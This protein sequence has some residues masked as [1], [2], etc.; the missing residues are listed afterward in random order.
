MPAP[1]NVLFICTGNCCRSQMSEAILRHYGGDR[2]NA[3]SAGAEPAGFV[4]PLVLEVLAR[5]NVS[6]EGLYSK[7]WDEF[8]DRKMD[9]IITVCDHAASRPCP[10][11]PGHPATAHWGLYDPS[12]HPGTEEERI[13]T[14]LKVAQIIKHRVKQLIQLPL[15]GMNEQQIKDE[16]NKIGET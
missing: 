12:F 1:Y 6:D 2:F 16:L 4:H 13:A 11:W 14:A 5:M 8:S 3:Y 9:F 10:T 7:S 15:D